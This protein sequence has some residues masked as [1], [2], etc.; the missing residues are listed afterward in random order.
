MNPK[1]AFQPSSFSDLDGREERTL[2]RIAKL[3]LWTSREGSDGYARW[4]RNDATSRQGWFE[5]SI[6]FQP[7]QSLLDK[8]LIEMVDSPTDPECLWLTPTAKG[9]M[10]AR[11]TDTF[12]GPLP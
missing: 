5:E 10:I 11:L 4:G 12:E 7:I 3:C 8:S 1:D 9:W 6:Y 2:R